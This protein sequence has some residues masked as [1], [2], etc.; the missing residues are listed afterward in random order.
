[1]NFQKS[2]VNGGK[3]KNRRNFI[4]LL[5]L[6]ASLAS[7]G[8]HASFM[9]DLFRSSELLFLNEGKVKKLS[10]K[11]KTN[12]ENLVH[13]M[14][15]SQ[16]ATHRTVRKT[17]ELSRNAS[18][19]FFQ[20]RKHY[21]DPSHTRG[22]YQELRGSFRRT[23]RAI[24]REMLSESDE[25]RAEDMLDRIGNALDRLADHYSDAAHH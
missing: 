22:D 7:S 10:R 20:V 11:I 17:R 12:A 16:D 4:V 13:L 19:F 9:T 5:A 21:S 6:L 3:M 24:R 8:I 25:T 23:K 14:E 18:H 15:T 1:M 2:K